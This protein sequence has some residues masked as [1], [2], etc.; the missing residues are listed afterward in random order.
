MEVPKKFKLKGLIG[1][2]AEEAVKPIIESYFNV[3]LKKT[4][5]YHIFDFIDEAKVYYELKARL[6]KYNRYPTTMVGA[7]KINV[8]RSVNKIGYFIFL[9]TDGLYYYKYDKDNKDPLIF[10]EGGR[11]DR[12]KEELKL[13][14]Y[15]PIELL[16]RI[17]F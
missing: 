11:K 8:L 3:K 1:D 17:D 15:I 16:I 5:T 13:Y 9:F 12:G 4:D 14:C 6:N 2:E 10:E 7:N